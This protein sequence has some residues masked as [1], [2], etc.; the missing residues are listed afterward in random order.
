V[1]V[2]LDANAFMMAYQFRVDIFTGINELIGSFQ[3]I[4]LPSVEK[5]LK[6][7]AKKRGSA[8]SAARYGLLFLPE[9]D[10]C[11]EEPDLGTVDEK[12]LKYA[13]DNQCLV[14]TNDRLLKNRLLE[15]GIGVISLKNKKILE[16]FR[17]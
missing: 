2:L 11:E 15:R 9:T 1:R 3:P 4:T 5:E 12:I 7:L 14:V 10:I 8:G 13:T 16:L 17:R 6:N